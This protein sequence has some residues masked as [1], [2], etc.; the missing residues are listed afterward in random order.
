MDITVTH[1]GT[2]LGYRA[3]IHGHGGSGASGY[4]PTED[5]ARAHLAEVIAWNIEHNGRAIA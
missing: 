2:G 4:G 1:L 5:A 3:S